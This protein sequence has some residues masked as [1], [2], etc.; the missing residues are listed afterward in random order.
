MTKRS[1]YT[2]RLAEPDVI[3]IL[4]KNLGGLS[5]TNDA[6]NVVQDL[7]EA[8][9]DVDKLHLVYRDSIGRYDLMIT[10]RGK[11]DGFAPLGTKDEDKAVALARAG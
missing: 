7:V 3:V 8:G 6:D 4:D 2:W 11:F 1:D 10:A 9:N 5:V